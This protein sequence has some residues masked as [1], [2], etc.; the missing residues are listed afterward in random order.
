MNRLFQALAILLAGTL[1]LG[2][3]DLA[4]TGVSG[5]RQPG[6]ESRPVEAFSGIVQAG[7]MDVVYTCSAK[8]SL[9]IEG[10]SNLI[11]YVQTTVENGTLEVKVKDHTDLRTHQALRVYV[12][13]PAV[14]KLTL[15]GSG[16][17]LVP[18][19]LAPSGHLDLNLAGSGDLHVDSL[20]CPGVRLRQA[21][22]G[23][24]YVRGDTRDLSLK[25]VGSGN[26]HARYLRS[27]DARSI[28]VGSGNA[29]LYASKS[30]QSKIIGSGSLTYWGNPAS[31]S[32]RKLGSGSIQAEAN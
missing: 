14:N 13:G 7:S 4:M 8:R 28:L 19:F 17:L 3:C 22:S 20:N 9:R 2:S 18:G 27:E 1:I 32:N 11:P 21:G 15:A 6:S 5:N 10:E 29:E 16:K 24:I 23:D 31:V 25:L 26:V 30:L 12:S